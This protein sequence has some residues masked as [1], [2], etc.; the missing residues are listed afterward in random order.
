MQESVTKLKGAAAQ[1]PDGWLW[2][3]IVVF[4]TVWISTFVGTNDINNWLL[5]NTLVFLA[6]LFLIVTYRKYKFSTLSYVL[7]SIFLCLHVYGSKYT[8]AEN[9]FG[10]WLKDMLNLERN[11]YDRLI[12][13]GF[14][15]LLAYPIREM[16]IKWL[17]YPVKSAWFYPIQTTL[18]VSAMYEIIEWAVAD[19]FFKEQGMAYLGTQGDI[20][21]AQKDTFL[22]FW[23]AFLASTFISILQKYT[24][25]AKPGL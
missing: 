4:V 1:K 10:F 22:A 21:D 23:G 20:W 25:S 7:I 17:G 19:V 3:A 16:Y 12:H 24:S 14:G 8:Y 6:L 11:H 5:E 9:P 15:L 2:A 13:F 18:A